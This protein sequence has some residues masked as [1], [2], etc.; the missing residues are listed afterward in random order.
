[1]YLVDTV[2]NKDLRYNTDILLRSLP[3][4]GPK[5]NYREIPASVKPL[6]TTLKWLFEYHSG[7]LNDD[8][9][10]ILGNDF[11]QRDILYLTDEQR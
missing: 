9:K 8:V 5:G 6:S 1:M 3:N 4:V 7:Q 2:I 11:T 10:K